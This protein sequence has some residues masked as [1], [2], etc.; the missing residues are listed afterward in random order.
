MILYQCQ[1]PA[2]RR[3]PPV[4]NIT[5]LRN[6]EMRESPN[7]GMQSRFSSAIVMRKKDTA[8]LMATHEL[9][10]SSESVA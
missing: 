7:C 1:R 4:E 9:V 2:P 3:R 8:R 10:L 5:V 6:S